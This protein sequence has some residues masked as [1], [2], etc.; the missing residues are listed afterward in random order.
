M[1]EPEDYENSTLEEKRQ[2]GRYFHQ[3]DISN[4][5]YLDFIP[6]F[7][8]WTGPRPVD[9]TDEDYEENF[10]TEIMR[11]IEVALGK[12]KEKLKFVCI[13]RANYSFGYGYLYWIT[14]HVRNEDTGEIKTCICKVHHGIQA[15][16]EDDMIVQH[17]KFIPS[18]LT[19]PSQRSIF[20]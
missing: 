9:F 13:V 18:N 5:Y 3:I 19:Y 15:G 1:L 14:M 10:G 16:D 6:T 17:F 8:L 4:C 12:Q 2:Y 11:C 20:E 7:P